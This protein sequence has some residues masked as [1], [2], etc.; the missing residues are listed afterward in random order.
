MLEYAVCVI[1]V[2]MSEFLNM[3]CCCVT[4]LGVSVL[5]VYRF[6]RLVFRAEGRYS[7]ERKP[8][9]LR[10]DEVRPGYGNGVNSMFV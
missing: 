10:L 3:L 9:K 2:S 7:I 6:V 8:R 1:I 4:G 5:V